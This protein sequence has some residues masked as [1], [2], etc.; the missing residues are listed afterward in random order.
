MLGRTIYWQPQVA[1]DLGLLLQKLGILSSL[2]QNLRGWNP[3]PGTMLVVCDPASGEMYV[4]DD[5]TAVE[6][7]LLSGTYECPT[8]QGNQVS[9]LSWFPMTSTFEAGGEDYGRWNIYREEGYNR[10][11]EEIN[12]PARAE[13]SRGPLNAQKWCDLMRGMKEM[14]QV[15]DNMERWSTEFIKNHLVK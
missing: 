6:L 1:I 7:N 14:R 8:G 3:I 5:L 15:M 13:S 10:H 2:A 12:N 11:T 9:Y 4:D